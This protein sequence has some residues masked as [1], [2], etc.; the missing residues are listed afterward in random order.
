MNGV[1]L[2]NNQLSTE[3]IWMDGSLLFPKIDAIY[4]LGFM[5]WP[6]THDYNKFITV[7]MIGTECPFKMKMCTLDAKVDPNADET[8]MDS[9]FVS[10]LTYCIYFVNSIQ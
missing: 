7:Q 9:I 5:I 8:W 6:H 3:T 4:H 10:I 1:L 2:C